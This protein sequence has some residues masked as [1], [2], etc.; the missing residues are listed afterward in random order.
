MPHANA[1]QN[2]TG[3]TAICS[4]PSPAWI[5]ARCPMAEAIVPLQHFNYSH[6]GTD[7]WMPPM[8]GAMYL[9]G[10]YLLLRRRP[11]SRNARKF[12]LSANRRVRERESCW[13]LMSIICRILKSNGWAA[14]AL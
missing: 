1:N 7:V 9:L 10:S 12:R 11:T 3:L 14:R 4:L 8:F 6:E 2:S 13:L 5:A